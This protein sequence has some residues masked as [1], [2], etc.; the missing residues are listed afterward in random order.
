MPPVLLVTFFLIGSSFSGCV[1]TSPYTSQPLPVAQAERYIETEGVGQLPNRRLAIT[2]FGIEF[3]TKLLLPLPADQRRQVPGEIR[4]VPHGHKAVVLSLSEDRMQS[5]ADQAYTQLVEDLQTAG[6]DIIPYETYNNLPTY[7]TLINLGGHESPTS[8][9]FRL[10]CPDNVVQGEALVFA[11]TGLKW[12]SPP[13][14]EIGSRLGNTL[15][16]LGSELHLMGRGLLGEEAI[17]QVEVDLANIL[18]A[19]LVKAYYVVSPVQR[20]VE[21]EVLNGTFPIEGSSVIGGG[22]TRL[23][24]RTLDAPIS[25]HLLGRNTPPRDGNAFV[26]LLRDVRVRDDH[27]SSRDLETYLDVIGKLFV[28]AMM[29]ER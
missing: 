23:A 14:E 15:A 24:F 10:G 18:N 26:R 6:Y 17:G 25:H 9:T 29:A 21:T 22:E 8:M 4:T 2:S 16:S 7:R 3:D 19:T 20:L 1:D 12:Y 28:L 27:T 11:P 13:V 5:L